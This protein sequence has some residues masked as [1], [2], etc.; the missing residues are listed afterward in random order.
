[1]L[2]VVIAL[3]NEERRFA[4]RYPDLRAFLDSL[5]E[6]WELL[7]VDDGSADRTFDWMTRLAAE[8]GRV[9]ALQFERN[10]GQGAALKLGMLSSRGDIVLYTDADLP[11]E[12]PLVRPLID[13]V[14]AGCDV[15]VASRWI[16]GAR[17]LQAQPPLRARLG[18]VFYGLIRALGLGSFHDVNCGLKVYRGEAVRVLFGFVRS[19][20]WAFNIEHLWLAR[21]FGYRVDEVPTEW[22]HR[23]DSRVR[24]FH[25]C[26]FTLWELGWI[27]ARQWLGIYPR[28]RP[29]RAETRGPIRS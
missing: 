21:R 11:V 22:S 12:L 6:P 23:A 1:M 25:D 20:R 16:G 28:C 13:R 5:D 19:W 8:D 27:K 3:Y 7:L 26:L 18:K 2:S 4:Q 17:I 14:R 15:A 24:V 9:R 10:M 29:G